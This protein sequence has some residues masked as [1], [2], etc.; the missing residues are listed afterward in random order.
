M[1]AVAQGR[2]VIEISSEIRRL[3]IVARK[4]SVIDLAVTVRPAYDIFAEELAHHVLSLIL[5]LA[6]SSLFL[7]P[8][9]LDGEMQPVHPLD[10]LRPD[11]AVMRAI[12]GRVLL[13]CWAHQF[14]FEQGGM[15]RQFWNPDDLRKI[16]G[17]FLLDQKMWKGA[18]SLVRSVFISIMG[19]REVKREVGK[20][21]AV[22]NTA[23]RLMCEPLQRCVWLAC[24][25]KSSRR[26]SCAT[27][28]RSTRCAS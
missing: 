3:L 21:T 15:T 11:A 6:N 26:S 27:A 14:R 28:S 24:T 7:H 19:P 22:R 4:L 18:R 10:G 16:D 2:E 23:C 17:L 5:D 20:C 9:S 13:E 8:S 25:P 1:P 12:V